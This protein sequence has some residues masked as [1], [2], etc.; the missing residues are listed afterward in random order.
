MS[1]EQKEIF[2]LSFD[3]S[4]LSFIRA[5]A[6][7]S[8]LKLIKLELEYFAIDCEVSNRKQES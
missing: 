7:P 3:I 1:V 6:C 4:H 2:H 8:H 5:G